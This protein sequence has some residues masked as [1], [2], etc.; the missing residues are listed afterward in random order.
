MKKD[1]LFRKYPSNEL[2]LK[3]L[4]A[5]GLNGPDDFHSFSKN[6]LKV[7][8]TI[9][10]ILEYKNELKDIYV[11]CKYKIYLTE[12]TIDNVLNILR[13]MLKTRN[14]SLDS[15]EKYIKCHK[16]IV[17]SIIHQKETECSDQIIQNIS[18]PNT[19]TFN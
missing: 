18:S 11:P 14:I 15:K 16:Y 19:L 9:D 5:F 17:Y 8:K 3:V 12:I 2:F 4:N 6:D 1:Q 13:H 10:K 7:L